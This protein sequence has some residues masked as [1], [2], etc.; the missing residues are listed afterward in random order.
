[1]GLLADKSSLVPDS[2]GSWYWQTTGGQKQA[3]KVFL[4]LTLYLRCFS[5]KDEVF[6]MA[7][8][9]ERLKPSV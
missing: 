8:M 2:L 1:M 3:V 5:G 7:P 9:S 6:A 4:F